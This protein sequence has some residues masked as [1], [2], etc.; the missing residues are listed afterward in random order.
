MWKQLYRA[1]R[2]RAFQAKRRF[3]VPIRD[4][5]RR[6]MVC[7]AATRH[8]LRIL[9]DASSYKVNHSAVRLASFFPDRHDSGCRERIPTRYFQK[10]IQIRCRQGEEGDRHDGA[11]PQHSEI[12][13]DSD[14]DSRRVLQDRNRQGKDRQD[15]DN[16]FRKSF[17]EQG[18]YVYNKDLRP[19]Q[20]Q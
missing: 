17:E 9:S 19:I 11:K 8:E 16:E 3:G 18:I 6:D 5:A 12:L 15:D 2:K 10:G 4:R 1:R 13:H 7:A 14:D 20:R